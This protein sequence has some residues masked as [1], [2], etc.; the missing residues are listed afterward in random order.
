MAST[1][2]V[3][4]GRYKYK[5]PKRGF[6]WQ[7][8]YAFN[9]DYYDEL[10]AL[11]RYDEAYTYASQYEFT[12]PQE[13]ERYIN[14][15]RS[16]EQQNRILNSMYS[17]VVVGSQDDEA[18]AF[19][20]NVLNPSSYK[21]IPDSNKYKQ[22]FD[23]YKL[24]L[25]R[26]PIT[27]ERADVIGIKLYN[28]KQYGPFGIDALSAD[29]PLNIDNFCK[30]SG[31]TI[32]KL[33]NGEIPGVTLETT[34]DGS[35]IKFSKDSDEANKL[36]YSLYRLQQQTG[37]RA[38]IKGYDADGKSL[39]DKPA[40][41]NVSG[42]TS[43]QPYIGTVNAMFGLF[44]DSDKRVENLISSNKLDTQVTS[45]TLCGFISDE[46]QQ[47]Y[48]AFKQGLIDH[49][50]Y[51][52]TKKELEEAY[53]LELRGMDASQVQMYSDVNNDGE[54]TILREL[55]TKDRV[56]LL[57]YI[58]ASLKSNR[59]TYQAAQSGGRLGTMISVAPVDTPKGTTIAGYYG[60]KINVF[61]PG[62]W[63]EQAQARINNN[64]TFK[65]MQ[66]V[67]NMETYGYDYN[68][69]NGKKIRTHTSIPNPNAEGASLDRYFTLVDDKNGGSEIAL[70][71]DEVA[72]YIDQD[73]IMQRSVDVLRRQYTN[74]NGQ[75]IHTD[76]LRRQAKE[77]ATEA[78]NN[79]Y[80][81]TIRLDPSD[82]FG[83][84][85]YKDENPN[86]TEKSKIDDTNLPY[87][88]YDKIQ[89]AYSIYDYILK[90][91]IYAQ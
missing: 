60:K 47:N 38:Y 52:A 69:K 30:V 70:T 46:L 33:R 84:S 41:D 36:L 32:E 80:S 73:L 40:K 87:D 16:V 83:D 19:R 43:T 82:I 25:G 3:D 74:K 79:L 50:T 17:K 31:Y 63:E 8:S 49:Q 7:G 64:T 45:T 48:N 77:I 68:L 51:A 21:Y 29:N 6:Q 2:E 67:G 15:L 23:R 75:L 65:A 57:D 13:Q 18:I 42:V 56:K 24:D 78:V 85:Y 61:V 11:R 66:E 55:E 22:Q 37:M 12:N 10:V 58:T 20:D 72:K 76:I 4:F 91:L 62:L 5:G 27:G 54:D 14:K 34:P 1:F 86:Q 89:Q 59:V 9:P 39:S 44:E 53:D 88:V 81:N 90:N 28:E 35:E 26:H 71:R